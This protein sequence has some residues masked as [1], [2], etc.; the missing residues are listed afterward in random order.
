MVDVNKLVNKGRKYFDEGKYDQAIESFNRVLD[1]E[2]ENIDVLIDVGIAFRHKE[3][4]D[5][6]IEYY[7]RVLEI[8]KAN[9]FALNNIGWSLQCKG[10]EESAIE[11]YK[12]ALE[13][14]P[15]YDTTVVNITKIYNNNKEFEKSVEIYKK[16]L[17][18]DHLNTAN[19]IDLGRAYRQLDEYDKAIGA[20]S[21]ALKLA[22]NDK[23]IWNN[24][25]WV[26][27]CQKEYDKAIEA[28]TK[29]MEIDWIYDLPFANLIKIYD[30][31][32]KE[33]SNDYIAWK[34]VA[35]GF[36]LGRDYNRSIDSIN[37]SLNIDPDFGEAISLR[38]KIVKAK[39]KFDNTPI[40]QQKIEDALNMF[41]SISY[42]VLLTDV[43]DYIKYK[44]TD[45]VFKDNEIK[46]LMLETIHK[47][48]LS[49]KLDKDKINFLSKGPEKKDSLT[50]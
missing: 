32:I 47:K 23:I 46:F 25:G 5:T 29:S 28:Y 2:P 13:I 7:N 14:D 3:D 1:L 19:W 42:S 8:D 9:K 6:A 15:S 34:N 26:Y 10:D 37:R 16:A 11:M 50:I 48:G 44:N 31:M 18:K 45:L 12:K 33:N 4:Y 27:Y 41:S 36:F 22:P 24:S 43:I 38:N 35:K 21:E 30:K 49:A 17:H 40:L 20:Y 39:T